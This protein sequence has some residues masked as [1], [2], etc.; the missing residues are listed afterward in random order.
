M[1]LS[2]ISD[3]WDLLMS[4]DPEKNRMGFDE[5]DR[6]YEDIPDYDSQIDQK[7]P[8]GFTSKFRKYDFNSF[9]VSN[10][11]FAYTNRK[12]ATVKL[13][14]F[15]VNEL[16]GKN[17][18]FEI[19]YLGVK[20]YTAH[21]GHVTECILWY[22]S[23][24]EKPEKGAMIHRIMCLEDCDFEIHFKSVGIKRRKGD[25]TTKIKNAHI[26]EVPDEKYDILPIKQL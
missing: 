1:K 6:L 5:W 13:T 14:L 10:V 26:Y 18:M 4:D 23:I 21:Y 8:K 3:F 9:E 16:Y 15:D 22:N 11:D 25:P 20:K 2:R 12:Y 17:L 7:L 19:T 24:F